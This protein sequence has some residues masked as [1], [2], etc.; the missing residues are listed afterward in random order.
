MNWRGRPLTSHDIIVNSIAATTTRT[1][2]RVEAALDTGTYD[3]GVK[4]T[5]AQIDALPLHRH[6]FHGDWNYMLDPAPADALAAPALAATGAARPAG[7]DHA[8][9]RDPEL[10]GM[11]ASQ[12]D[13]LISTATPALARQRE[14]LRHQ[15]RGGERRRA[16]G[17][18]AK[19]KLSDPERVLATVLHLRKI[20]T[21]ELIGKLFAVDRSTITNSVAEVRTLLEQHGHTIPASTARFRNPADVTAFLAS[22]H[23]KIKSPC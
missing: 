5:D 15:R 19:A 12:L 16:P 20:G 9:L 22:A 23:Q 7:P 8:D 14:Q 13:S 11:T 2:L 17:A 1:G 3:T 6:R 10:T 21:Q 18:G 4:V